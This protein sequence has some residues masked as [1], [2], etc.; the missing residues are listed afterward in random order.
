MNTNNYS[1]KYHP[2]KGTNGH[3]IMIGLSDDFVEFAKKQ[4]INKEK[5]ENLAEGIFQATG[6][7]NYKKEDKWFHRVCSW[8]EDEEGKETGLMFYLRVPG[9][10]AGITLEKKS[11]EWGYYSNNLDY[12]TQAAAVFGV[13]SCYFEEIEACIMLENLNNK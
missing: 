3:S 11:D 13:M 10:A 4:E 12:H 5:Y 6:W 8:K 9:N 7:P 2:S 1:I